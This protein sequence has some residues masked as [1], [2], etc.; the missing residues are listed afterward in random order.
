MRKFTWS[1]KGYFCF[2]IGHKFYRNYKIS[3]IKLVYCFLFFNGFKNKEMVLT[4][5]YIKGFGVGMTV[6]WLDHVQLY[7]CATLDSLIERFYYFLKVGFFDI[8]LAN[9]CL[10]VVYKSKRLQNM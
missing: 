7:S 2:E 4:L 9:L 5:Y 10:F 6:V 3:N 8:I 1:H